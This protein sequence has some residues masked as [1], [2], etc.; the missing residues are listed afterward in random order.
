MGKEDAYLHRPYVGSLCSRLLEGESRSDH[1]SGGV[2]S[3]NES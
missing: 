1:I 2:E 3:M